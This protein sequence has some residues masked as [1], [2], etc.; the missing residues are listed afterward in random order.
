MPLF[1]FLAD[2]PQKSETDEPSLNLLP[3]QLRQ[4]PFTPPALPALRDLHELCGEDDRRWLDTGI[5]LL[6]RDDCYAA[7]RCFRRL[8]E[9]APDRW[10]GNFEC[11]ANLAVSLR[12]QGRLREG[13]DH[14]RSAIAAAP[15]E[16]SVRRMLVEL[17]DELEFPSADVLREID[18]ALELA[19]A[20]DDLLQ[21]RQRYEYHANAGAKPDDG[22]D[23][24]DRS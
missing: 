11:Q 2:K 12:R 20:D 19:P 18:A 14:I 10:T 21:R 13:L 24:E 6:N 5:Y 16:L 15:N 17:M 8:L 3:P 1:D 23:G 22:N 9:Y 4:A 7:E